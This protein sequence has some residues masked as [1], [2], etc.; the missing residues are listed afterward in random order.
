[1]R[2]SRRMCIT[3]D[4]IRSENIDLNQPSLTPTRY[5]H[6]Y[7]TA[8]RNTVPM[9]EIAKA[10]FDTT[11]ELGRL[12]HDRSIDDLNDEEF[13]T[14]ITIIRSLGTCQDWIASTS[15]ILS[16]II[17]SK[18]PTARIA[19]ANLLAKLKNEDEQPLISVV[20]SAAISDDL[21]C[22]RLAAETMGY[23]EAE[24]GAMLP[25]ALRDADEKVRHFGLMAVQRLGPQAVPA[26][27]AIVEILCQEHGPDTDE[28]PQHYFRMDCCDAMRAIGHGAKQAVPHLL[29]IV[30]Q[31]FS[32]DEHRWLQL[33]AA[34]ALFAITDNPDKSI[35]VALATLVDSSRILVM[36][37]DLNYWLPCLAC[38]LLAELGP[39]AKAAIPR[40][41][42][43][44]HEERN[45]HT[46]TALQKAILKI[47]ERN[48]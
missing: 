3:T 24:G 22:R 26:V 19:A 16:K 7:D 20:S 30:A 31:Q 13:A 33:R 9:T 38:D 14:A 36:P 43:V 8:I 4:G 18:E 12:L 6:V 40:L 1:M 10:V 34:H 37:E 11:N 23:L 15:S 17:S 48:Q 45:Q 5:F 42:Q 44:L 2:G 28:I 47:E 35:E 27:H 21:F 41:R 46:R 32:D 39:S 25:I 29:S